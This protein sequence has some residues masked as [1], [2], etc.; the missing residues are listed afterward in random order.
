[1]IQTYLDFVLRWDTYFISIPFW[2]VFWLLLN[3]LAGKMGWKFLPSAIVLSLMGPVYYIILPMLI[4]LA[5]I[6]IPYFYIECKYF[7]PIK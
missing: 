7:N 6:S 1:M 5:I 3:R 4:A 2:I